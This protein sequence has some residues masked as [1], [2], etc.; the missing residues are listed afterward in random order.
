MYNDD[1]YER[2]SATV[3]I[4]VVMIVVIVTAFALWW[5]RDTIFPETS[6]ESEDIVVTDTLE[7][8]QL[9]DTLGQ[10]FIYNDMKVSDTELQDI[11]PNNNS[12]SL[13][14]E[15]TPV[16]NNNSSTSKVIVPVIDQNLLF[17]PA[18]SI[19][20]VVMNSRAVPMLFIGADEAT[21]IA[22]NPV[23]DKVDN[24]PFS[25]FSKSY[26]EAGRQCI[27]I[28]DRGYSGY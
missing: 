3:V 27:F 24:Y 17:V 16:V 28:T 8:S 1:D 25:K 5:H 7:K 10:L 22:Y 18:P 11:S 21:V 20:T 9:D 13:A 14:N 6:V 15:L 12:V 26:D 4:A 2:N 19:V 23:S